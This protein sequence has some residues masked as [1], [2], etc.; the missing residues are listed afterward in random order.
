MQL[1]GSGVKFDKQKHKKHI[2]LFKNGQTSKVGELIAPTSDFTTNTN[3]KSKLSGFIPSQSLD[4]FHEKPKLHSTPQDEHQQHNDQ[5]N[6]EQA[7]SV[8]QLSHE[9]VNALRSEHNIFVKGASEAPPQPISS[10]AELTARYATRKYL[11]KNIVEMMKWNSPTPIQMQAIPALL[12]GHEI[13]ASAPTGSGKTAAY[14]IPILSALKEPAKDGFRA[15]VI[16]PTRVLAEQIERDFQSLAK[17]KDWR[18]SVSTSTKNLQK[19][20]EKL[21]SKRHGLL[22]S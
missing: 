6:S 21:K 4:F 8:K 17:G 11:I 15:L 20:K 22:C 1:T 10:F 16:V 9:Q 2:D 3:S 14:A 13:L 18:I 12:D 7:S 5:D 19:M